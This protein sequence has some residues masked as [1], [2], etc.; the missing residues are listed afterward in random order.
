LT[1]FDEA[2]T[3]AKALPETIQTEVDAKKAAVD[4]AIDKLVKKPE[5]KELGFEVSDVDNSIYGT[6]IITVTLK[7]IPEGKTAENYKVTIDGVEAKYANGKFA[8]GI[9][10][11]VTKEQAEALVI[12][13]EK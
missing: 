1:A 5:D 11:V 10:K 6:S 7:N 8:A 13:E 9:K 2:L 12:V 4:A 3:A